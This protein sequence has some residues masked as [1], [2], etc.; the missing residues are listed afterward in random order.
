[1][2]EH[3]RESQEH[4][5]RFDA[6]SQLV[7]R[8]AHDFSNLLAT[9]V[10]N[11]NL[12]EKKCTDPTALSFA[13][14]ALR[15]ADRGTILTQRLLAL[16]GKQQLTPTPTDL[17]RF[18]SGLRDALA[19]LAGPE[20]ELVLRFHDELWPVSI[21]PDQIE[22]A[23]TSLVGNSRD[24]MPRGGHL[25]IELANT[26]IP[27]A[28]AEL[29]AGDYVLLSLEDTGEGLS[30]EVLQ[31]AFEPFFTTRAG[32]DHLG[33]GLNIV[34]GIAKQH[35]GSARVMRTATGGCRAE[36]YLP[37]A[38]EAKRVVSHDQKLAQGIGSPPKATVLVVDDDPDL[39]A[40]AEDGLNSL[41]CDVLL[42]DSGM[43]ALD[44]LAS[45]PLVDL[46]MV[47]MRM[48]GMNGLE[49]VRR[50]RAM[51]PGLKALVMTGAAEVPELH[52]SKDA[53]AVLRKPFR[54]AELAQG[55]AAVL[56]GKPQ[57]PR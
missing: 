33:L 24:A 35:G 25:T 56:S 1:M 20:V 6:L 22:L 34:Q 23:L 37:R 10:L 45:H 36:I 39:R 3:D 55:I 52:G 30:E 7:G 18:V 48:A 53:T 16:A 11:L 50:A 57:S 49:L 9:I 54:A 2:T 47:D 38:G 5:R 17:P 26:R 32:Q 43:T 4:A 40:V 28:T 51:R 8:F 46:L 29:A 14:S 44:V 12:I 21:D 19:R 42:A 41:G 27:A 13:S 31:R 15:A